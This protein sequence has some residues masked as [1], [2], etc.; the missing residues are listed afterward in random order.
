M[1]SYG[2][3]GNASPTLFNVLFYNNTAA[4]NVGAMYCWGGNASGDCHAQLTNCA[5]INNRALNG[6]AGA[7]IS[8]N[9]DENQ[10]TISGNSS[11]TLKNCIV[12]GNSATGAGQQFYS[13]GN[14]SIFATYSIIDM[15]GQSGNH[16]LSGSTTGN[17]TTNP[18][19]IDI[20]NAI[21]LDNCWLTLDDGLYL[22]NASPGLNGGENTG[23]HSTDIAGNARIIANTVD[24]GVYEN[25]NTVSI[26]EKLKSNKMNIYPNPTNSILMVEAN[27]FEVIN[28]YNSLG[29][30]MNDRVNFSDKLHGKIIIDCSALANGIYLLNINNQSTTVLIQH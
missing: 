28:L 8:D 12:W 11:V 19:F 24:M 13:K 6:F 3:N 14:G 16:I 30:N 22:Q 9:I 25:S 23:I 18:Q 10:T 7:F 29:Q 1:D 27:D 17:I 26:D 20:N 5:F 2:V 21:G 4:T 15:S